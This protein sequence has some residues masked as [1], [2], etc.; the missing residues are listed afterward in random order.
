MPCWPFKGFRLSLEEERGNI[1][2][3]NRAIVF[4]IQRSQGR[5]STQRLEGYC[6]KLSKT[7]GLYQAVALG[8]VK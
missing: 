4:K 3:S 2:V 1:T 8:S 7:R 5:S 6:N